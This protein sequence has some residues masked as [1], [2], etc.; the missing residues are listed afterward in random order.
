[1]D[2]IVGVLQNQYLQRC[3]VNQRYS[4]RAYARSLD[5]PV[6]S[7]SEILKGKRPMTRKLRLKIGKALHM[8][9]QQIEAFEAREHGNSSRADL[10]NSEIDYQQIAID[11][12]TII[13]E[14]YHYG[15]LQLLRTKN[16]NPD[17]RWMARRLGVTVPEIKLALERLLRVG[18]LHK[19]EEGT[20]I[21]VTD[22]NTSHLKSD[23]TNEQLRGF[24]IQALHKAIHALQTVPI[25]QRDNTSMTFS[26]SKKSI[27]F[28]KKE[29]AK[30]RRSL[31]RK[32]EKLDEPDEVY[33]LAISLTPL[34]NIEPEFTE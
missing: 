4:L 6:S 15:I 30:F 17:N 32:L 3:R 25:T 34:T 27:P 5:I 33:Q 19:N 16:F 28:A 26:M 2:S 14:W 22:G 20:L 10:A 24:Q 29:I 12:F 23:F 7:L 18:I 8:S 1:M 9:D 11:S 31:T 21:D 13:S